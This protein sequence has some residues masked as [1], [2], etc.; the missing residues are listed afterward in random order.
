LLYIEQLEK[1]HRRYIEARGKHIGLQAAE[2]VAPA[3]YK[4]S[5]MTSNACRMLAF[6]SDLVGALRIGTKG[7]IKFI[8]DKDGLK[9]YA[10][11][12]SV[13]RWTD[14]IDKWIRAEE[15]QVIRDLL[16]GAE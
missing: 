11:V 13:E 5:R 8:T 1:M 15:S 14:E 16:G 7:L 10:D 12:V 3:N 6:Y 2:R 9:S 4:I